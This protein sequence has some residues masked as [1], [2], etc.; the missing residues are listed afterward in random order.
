MV[1][2]QRLTVRPGQTELNISLAYDFLTEE[3]GGISER[4]DGPAPDV[5]YIVVQMGSQWELLEDEHV[6]HLEDAGA[7]MP[8]AGVT[9]ENGVPLRHTDWIYDSVLLVDSVRVE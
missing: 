4:N 1:M 2:E 8:L 6:F 9:L 3:Q 7:L 5:F